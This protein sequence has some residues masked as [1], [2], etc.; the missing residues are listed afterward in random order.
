MHGFAFR[1]PIDTMPSPETTLD[2]SV[3]WEGVVLWSGMHRPPG[4]DGTLIGI[5]VCAVPGERLRSVSLNIY[6]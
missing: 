4:M 5:G 6:S 3:A 1:P 2:V